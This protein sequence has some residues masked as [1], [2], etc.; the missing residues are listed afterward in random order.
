MGEGDEPPGQ[1]EDDPADCKRHGE[2]EQVPSPLNVDHCG[3][4][5]GEEAAA[6]F[7]DVDSRYVAF[8]VLTDETTLGQSRQ[9]PPET[10]LAKHR[11]HLCACTII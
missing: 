4:Y 7:V 11:R 2:N 5:I 10:L 3:E 9:Q 1:S 6:S 8:A